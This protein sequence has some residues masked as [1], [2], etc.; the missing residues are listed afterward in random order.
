VTGGAIVLA[1][2]GIELDRLRRIAAHLAVELL[3]VSIDMG[4]WLNGG[5]IGGGAIEPGAATTN[6]VPARNIILLSIAASVAE[7]RGADRIYLGATAS[8][9]HHPDCRPAFMAAFGTA[10][11]LGQDA[12]PEVRTP[13]IG[14]SK[15][16]IVQAAIAMNVPLEFTWSCHLAGPNPCMGCAP[17][18]LRRQTFADLGLRD[19]QWSQ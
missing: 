3:L 2:G 13:L 16:Q 18:Q 10:L 5:L 1:S 9:H 4:G 11:S 17:C 14:L 19:S 7:A 6:Y 12:P 15:A 8:D